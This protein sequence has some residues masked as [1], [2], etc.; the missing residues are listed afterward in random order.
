MGQGPSTDLES[1]TA[2]KC[3]LIAQMGIQTQAIWLKDQACYHWATDPDLVDMLDHD[4]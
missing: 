4:N 2:K 1:K 3:G